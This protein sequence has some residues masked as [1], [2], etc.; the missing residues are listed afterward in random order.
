LSGAFSISFTTYTS[1]LIL[2]FFAAAV[3]V[4]PILVFSFSSGD[5]IPEA[6]DITDVNGAIDPLSVLVDKRGA[7]FGASLLIATLGVLVG[8]STVGVPVWAVTVPPAVIMLFRD[9]YHDLS[10]SRKPLDQAPEQGFELEQLPPASGST[11]TAQRRRPLPIKF[12]Q[13]LTPE[14]YLAR[15]PTVAIVC[16]RLPV[17][18]LPFAFL[19][20]ILV[21]GLT[22]KG[23]VELLAKWWSHWAVETGPVG[24]VAGMGLISCILCNVRLCFFFFDL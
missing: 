8:T 21:Q 6:I 17:S 11:P 10:D 7:I 23:W 14:Y 2:P 3:I 18:L 4:F 1:H 9:I 12:K 24:A 22:T 5:L 20:F 16:K 15:L 19:M 13:L